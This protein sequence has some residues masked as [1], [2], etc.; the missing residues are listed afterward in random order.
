MRRRIVFVAGGLAVG[1]LLVGAL[2]IAAVELTHPRNEA[3]YIDYMRTYGGAASPINNPPSAAALIAEGDRACGWLGGQPWAL[4]RTSDQYRILSVQDRYNQQTAGH[5]APGLVN[6]DRLGIA[7]GA[8]AYLC[9][10]AM[11]LR[12]PH[13]IFSD[14]HQ[15]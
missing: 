3:A 15:D 9:P 6:P 1:L 14:P 4:W 8:W 13:F 11:E 2:A 12:K 5:T 10:A 7:A